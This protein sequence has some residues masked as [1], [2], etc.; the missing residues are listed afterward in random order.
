MLL[1]VVDSYLALSLPFSHKM[2]LV[3]GKKLEKVKVSNE[4]CSNL[5]WLC[6]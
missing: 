3:G 2:L 4:I 1:T 6:Y 5:N